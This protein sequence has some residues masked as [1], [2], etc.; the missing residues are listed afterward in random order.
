[1]FRMLIVDDEKWQREGLCEFLD[2]HRLG[3]EVAGCARNGAEALRMSHEIRPQIVLTDI[4]MPVMDGIEMSRALHQMN[5]SVRII[6]LS[7]HDDFQYAKA[8]FSFQACEY[9][10][11]PIEKPELEHAICRAVASL[12]EEDRWFAEQETLRGHLLKPVDTRGR[13]RL[14]DYLDRKLRLSDLDNGQSALPAFAGVETFIAIVSFHPARCGQGACS[15]QT[16]DIHMKTNTA[17]VPDIT[18][19][20]E[21]LGQYIGNN[22]GIICLSPSLD[23]AVLWLHAAV[24]KEKLDF[25][26]TRLH[27]EILENLGLE[28][29]LAMG[30][31][32]TEL[33]DAQIS[34]SQ[35]RMAMGILFLADDGEILFRKSAESMRHEPEVSGILMR[36]PGEM[37]SCIIHLF[38][39]GRPVEAEARL[40]VFL[41]SIRRDRGE[42]LLLFQSFLSAL[43][44]ILGTGNHENGSATFL[45][46]V[47]H[48][49][50]LSANQKQL[51]SRAQTR[52]QLVRCLSGLMDCSC[53]KTEE[54]ESLIGDIRNL[55][56]ERYAQGIGLKEISGHVH[57]SPYYVGEIFKKH[58]GVAFTQYLNDFRLD[59]ARQILIATNHQVAR[60]ARFVGISNR[61]YFCK[62]FKD[63]YGLSPVEFRNATKGSR[64]RV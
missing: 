39:A 51:R 16:T 61:S 17:S 24:W 11:K 12:Q 31:A 43:M 6:L 5:P 7:G 40:E 14:M 29:T 34:Y 30:T 20:H 63:K 55:I 25:E 27:G 57:L 22:G 4:M 28:S 21:H 41:T 1:M 52:Q 60:I 18:T 53:R 9:L 32:F 62:L 8:A 54:A 38:Q 42:A 37:A 13:T 59:K 56:A 10:L 47:S 44:R 35:A 23:E 50:F 36:E 2:W 45:Q 19:L 46:A 33:S 49:T 64:T 3:I 15:A 48:V 58:E 26:W